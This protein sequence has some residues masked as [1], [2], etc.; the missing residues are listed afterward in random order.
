MPRKKS[1]RYTSDSTVSQLNLKANR[2]TKKEFAEK[3]TTQNMEVRYCGRL[4]CAFFS[5]RSNYTKHLTLDG[6]RHY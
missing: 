4:H 1:I 3:M 5:A 2:L 6:V